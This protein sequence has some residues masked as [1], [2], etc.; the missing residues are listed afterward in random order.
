MGPVPPGSWKVRLMSTPW[1]WEGWEISGEPFTKQWIWVQ[2][3]C[4]AMA[5]HPRP[6]AVV[7]KDGR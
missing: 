6:R 1:G 3:Q 5:G 7:G 2:G 4:P